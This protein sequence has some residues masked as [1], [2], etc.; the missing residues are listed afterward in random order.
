MMSKLRSVFLIALITIMLSAKLGQVD[1]QSINASGDG[2]LRRIFVPILMYH[3]VSPLPENADPYRTDLTVEPEIFR[4][5]LEYL[6]QHGYQTISPYLLH[7]ALNFGKPLPTNPIILTFDDGYNDHY[8]IVFPMLREFGFI[9]TFFIITGRADEGNQDYLSWSQ[10]TEMSQ[11][12]MQM[13]AHSRTHRELA[14]RDVPFLVYEIIGSLQ[15]L[16]AHT[17]VPSRVFAY[18]SGRYDDDTLRVMNSSPVLR[19]MT[20]RTGAYHTTDN[21]MELQRLRVIGNMSANALGEMIAGS[22]R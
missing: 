12:G 2:T 5:H 3:Y 20:T 18:P 7:E 14:N 13:E 17:G 15:S 4:S 19:A 22:R 8:P 21:A 10:I 16:E 9:G 6:H 1:A 11:A